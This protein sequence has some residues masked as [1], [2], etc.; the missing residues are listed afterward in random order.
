MYLET[1]EIRVY[2][3][4]KLHFHTSKS[5]VWVFKIFV[6]YMIWMASSNISY[7]ET[8][9]NWQLPERKKRIW[10]KPHKHDSR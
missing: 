2:M 9:F 10:L 7:I 5:I 1:I 8:W 3:V 4:Y 6:M